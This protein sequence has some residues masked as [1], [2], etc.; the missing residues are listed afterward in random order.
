LAAAVANPSYFGGNEAV[1]QQVQQAMRRNPTQFA[2]MLDANPQLGMMLASIFT[3]EQLSQMF[4]DVGFSQG[5]GNPPPPQPPSLAQA[6]MM[7]GGRGMGGGMGMGM[8]MPPMRA[9][10]GLVDMPGYYQR[11]GTSAV[12]EQ[13][14]DRGENWR[15]PDVGAYWSK[16]FNDRAW[17]E[18]LRTRPEST[19]IEDRRDQTYSLPDESR[20]FDMPSTTSSP[21]YR[22]R[23]GAIDTDQDH[24]SIEDHR[25][26]VPFTMAQGG[27]VPLR[28]QAGGG[29]SEGTIQQLGNQAQQRAQKVLGDFPPFTTPTFQLGGVTPKL[30]ISEMNTAFKQAHFGGINERAAESAVMGRAPGVH[31]INSHVPGRVD[32]IP[33][34]ARTGSYVMPADVVSGLGQGNTHAGARMWGQAISHSIGPMGIQN[35]IKARAMKAPSL[36]MPSPGLN[37]KTGIGKGAFVGFA[38]GG[39][40]ND[41][42]EYTPIIT[43]GGELIIDPEIVEALGRGDADAGKKML[44]DSAVHVRRQTV[45]HLKDLPG[46]V[47]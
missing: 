1:A 5:E 13:Q 15:M 38:D 10:G 2:A 28:R 11:G 8:G 14:P 6:M 4:A 39:G 41:D 7:G 42:G 32:R 21:Q 36:R 44:A 37:P 9:Q 26:V 23:G 24:R 22:I 20:Y 27:L 29:L 12:Y 43:A 3:P 19:N 47:K 30:G 31:L 16:R 35:A 17:D 25:P 33:M 46:P 34:R 40:V 45:K 18:W